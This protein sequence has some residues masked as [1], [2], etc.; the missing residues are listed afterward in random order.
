MAENF[1]EFI[2]LHERRLMTKDVDKLENVITS[3]VNRASSTLGSN[4]GD[5]LTE[6]INK[7]F[8]GLKTFQ[9]TLAKHELYDNFYE[10]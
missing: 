9:K 6:S 1:D 8:D 4:G 3:V 7:M 10:E 5:E 2:A